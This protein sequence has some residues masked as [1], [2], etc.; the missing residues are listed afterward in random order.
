VIEVK[1]LLE[2]DWSGDD[3]R[4]LSIIRSALGS[5]DISPPQGPI[6]RAE[7][8]GLN[9][10]ELFKQSSLFEKNE[11]LMAC[12]KNL[13]T[14]A[15]AIEKVGMGYAAKMSLLALSLE[16]RVLYSIF[17]FDEASH[18]HAVSAYLERT[19][20]ELSSNPFLK[21]LSQLIEGED[22]QVLVFVIQIILEGWGLSHYRLMHDACTDSGFKVILK[23]I[24]KD[25]AKHH[26]SGLTLIQRSDLS[27]SQ[28]KRIAEI[29]SLMLGMIQSGPRSVVDIV[30]KI[31]GGLSTHERIK[32][33][34]ELRC[35]QQSQ[36]KLDL[37]R[38]LIPSELSKL[39]DTLE[40]QN[41]FKAFSAV[42]CATL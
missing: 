9:Q 41:S 22:K 11:I 10:C 37:L 14:E 21:M 33:F 36:L 7:F 31:K 20:T 23:K 18:F 29:L 32:L 38:S 27:Q 1:D 4:L 26:A 42:Q 15:Y 30:E 24:L 34:E 16:E 35:D 6:W 5:N 3:R 8:F 39:T 13:L 25:E 19:P 40:R 28:I 17:S 2:I 12:S